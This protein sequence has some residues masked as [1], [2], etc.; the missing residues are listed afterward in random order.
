VL[1]G[2]DTIE[3][4]I[5]VTQDQQLVLRHE[6]RLPDRRLVRD[7]TL[8][9]LRAQRP[10]TLTLGDAVDEVGDKAKLLLDTKDV[11]A[12]VPLGRWLRRRRHRQPVMVCS[13]NR[14]VLLHLREQAPGVERWQSLPEVGSGRARAVASVTR[15]LA[16]AWLTGRGGSV[17]RELARGAVAAVESPS[18]G[19]WHVAG[20][21]WRRD[22]PALIDGLSAGVSP[23]G[24]TVEHR[25][26]SPELCTAAQRRGLR[27]VAWTINAAD[28]LHRAVESGVRTVTTDR[29]VDMR[30]A[31]A[32]LHPGGVAPSA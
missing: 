26:I 20:S 31:L 21:P 3:L 8:D 5:C 1:I 25:L 30:L 29:V 4:D 13:S 14:A 12:T 16:H 32:G 6:V 11:A 22:L 2:V 27:L 24:M 10:E 9:Q 7:I 28:H 15:T 19:A 23:A 18:A 17:V